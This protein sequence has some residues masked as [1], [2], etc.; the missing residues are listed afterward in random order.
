MTLQELNEKYH[1]RPVELGAWEHPMFGAPPNMGFSI[2]AQFSDGKFYNLRATL[3]VDGM[4][5]PHQMRHGIGE[6]GKIMDVRVRDAYEKEIPDGGDRFAADIENLIAPLVGLPGNGGKTLCVRN[7]VYPYDIVDVI[8]RRGRREEL[9]SAWEKVKRE[10]VHY[11]AC[12]F[13]FPEPED[14]SEDYG[15]ATV[16]VK[17]NGKEIQPLAALRRYMERTIC[18]GSPSWTRSISW[19]DLRNEMLDQMFEKVGVK[20]PP[21]AHELCYMANGRK[22]EKWDRVVEK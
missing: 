17:V 11:I 1:G 22:P 14:L 21:Q 10:L 2:E 7:N 15:G 19:V 13:E 5:L 8:R 9:D 20:L 4:D 16:R 18:S 6:F 12:K 3:V